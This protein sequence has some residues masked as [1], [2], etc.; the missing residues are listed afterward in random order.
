MSR[1]NPFTSF[2]GDGRALVK[3]ERSPPYSAMVTVSDSRSRT[4]MKTLTHIVPV[5]ENRSRLIWQV[6]RIDS[7]TIL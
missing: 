4:V 2:F 6:R 7:A 1:T 3:M 5:S